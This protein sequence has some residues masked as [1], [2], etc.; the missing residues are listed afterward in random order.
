MKSW[1]A[2]RRQRRVLLIA[3]SKRREKWVTTTAAAAAARSPSKCH[4]VR[5][6][7]R[8]RE[9]RRRNSKYA[10]SANC[11]ARIQATTLAMIKWSFDFCSSLRR[12]RRGSRWRIAD[13]LRVRAVD[14]GA[15]S[16]ADDH[17][18]RDHTTAHGRSWQSSVPLL[19][20]SGARFYYPRTR[21][22]GQRLH[23]RWD[24]HFHRWDCFFFLPSRIS[25]TTALR[26]NSPPRVRA[27]GSATI[28]TS[29]YMF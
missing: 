22:A 12:K 4:C 6:T 8:W 25:V 17:R 7:S 10:R 14:L 9:K 15:V 20:L 1:G 29:K 11:I 23:L 16:T 18:L 13:V 5:G 21:A 2:H 26:G 24:L 28:L 27:S 3:M 19:R